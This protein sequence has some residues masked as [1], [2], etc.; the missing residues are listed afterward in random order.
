MKTAE[1]TDALIIIRDRTTDRWDKEVLAE[2]CNR[3]VELEE[4]VGKKSKDEHEEWT[5]HDGAGQP[6]DDAIRVTV[7]YRGGFIS[8]HATAFFHATFRHDRWTWDAMDVRPTDIIAY[9]VQP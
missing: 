1:L 5:E 6:V 8:R 9:R 4:R 7:K 3:L 2:A